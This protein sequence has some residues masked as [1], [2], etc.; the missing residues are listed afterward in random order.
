MKKTIGVLAH[1]D[2][3]KTTFSEQVLYHTKSIKTRGRVDHKNS[4]LD[5]HDIEKKR[6]ITVFSDQAVFDIND[7]TYYLIDTPGHIDF[8]C[9]MERAIRI[10]DYAIVIV[11][12]VEGVQ[13][14][15]ETVW[16]LLRKYKVPTF[17]FINKLDRTGADLKR[18]LQEINNN[19][20]KD[21]CFITDL[22]EMNE[23]VIEFIAEKDELLLEK[24]LNDEYE[25]NLWVNK[26]R[27]LI[28][29][30]KIYPCFSGSALQD[31]GIREFLNVLEE[32]TSTNYDSSCEFSGIVNKIRY[33]SNGTRITFI[34]ALSGKLK[35]RDEIEISKADT[36]I[37][38][39]I[40]SIRIYNGNKFIT[41]DEVE[42][43][44]VFAV[45]GL[46]TVN[47]GDGIGILNNKVN[48]NMI[49]T[50]M[51]SVIYDESYNEKEVLKYF[52]ILEAEDPALNVL[53]NETHKEIQVHIMGKIQL[54]VLKEIVYERFNLKVDFGPCE[55]MYKET[56]TN[57]VRGYGHFEPLK[58]YA[59]VHLKLEAQAR[60]TG[61]VFEN[62]CHADDLTTGQQNLIKTHIFERNHH[63]L[64]TGSDITDIKVTLLTGRAHNK[65][66]EGGDFREAT[67]RALRQGLEKAHNILL[68]PFYRFTIDVEL[69]YMGRV[70]S[71]I[72][73]LSGKFNTPET[74]LNKVRIMGR[75]PVST[76]MDYS[77]ELIAFTK[78]KGNIS[79]MFDGYDI[80]H[81]TDEIV[82][83]IGYNKNADIE[84]SSNSVF[85]SKGQGFI[86]PW[87][88]AEKY[89][90]CE[91]LE[92]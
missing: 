54:E 82:E 38:E 83:K 12:A 13:G 34:K 76:F 14:H 17:F 71:D 15:T 55:I 27:D 39:K 58:H 11:S 77:M 31:E 20:S 46:S 35:V 61:I 22:E 62:K 29:E 48:F 8:S 2:A 86:V 10:M 5:S 49:P 6:G 51:S 73:K 60:G 57:E 47:A 26:L 33:D 32:L 24:Y 63:G 72:Q 43:G 68:E 81:N 65:H 56:I 59:E 1:V 30:N 74:N 79:L 88:E 3:G 21:V 89:M 9:E 23:E 64:L 53:W 50:L 41:V 42:A 66:T 18:V 40:S 67:Y 25:N 37:K 52:K 45:T 90:H 69:D 28:R 87:N 84:Y 70:L 4:F 85:C 92:E 80:C 36:N 78:G 91:I 44:D 19:L 75:V 16:N 7:S